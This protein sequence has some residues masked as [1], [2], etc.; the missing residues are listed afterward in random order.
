MLFFDIR[1][2]KYLE[3]DCGICGH[4]FTMNV[5]NGWLVSWIVSQYSFE[6]K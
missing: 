4:A 1:A 5:G 6:I 3:C 2:G